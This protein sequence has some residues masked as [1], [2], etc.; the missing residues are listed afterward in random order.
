VTALPKYGTLN[1]TV[2]HTP[3]PYGDWRESFEADSAGQ[4]VPKLGSERALG[5]CNGPDSYFNL[6]TQSP[7][8]VFQHCPDNFGVGPLLG[9]RVLG[10]TP[11]PVY[12]RNE[13][14]VVYKP[15]QGYLGPDYFTYIIYDGQTTQT[16]EISS[17]EQGTRNEVTVHVRKC[18]PFVNRIKRGVNATVSPAF[19]V[20]GTHI[21][22]QCA[23]T[24]TSMVNN[25]TICDEA[26]VTVCNSAAN[27]PAVASREHFLAMC[28]VCMDPRRGLNNG[29]C[30]TQTIRAVS[31]LASRGLCQATSGLTGTPF[32]DCSTETVTEPGREATN[33][34]TVRP[35]TLM[36][37][38]QRLKDSF[39]AYGWYHTPQLT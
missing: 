6:S 5:Y 20:D 2:P 16:H 25:R 1:Y 7:D 23:Q 13:R 14:V 32:M 19:G 11:V 12:L 8:N 31:L 3:S 18:R 30:Q 4:L 17:G 15:R 36:G 28:L 22:C 35:P 26:R 39:G 29:E 10:D 33:Y 27:D 34:L 24:E 21:L 38:F 9:W 37:A